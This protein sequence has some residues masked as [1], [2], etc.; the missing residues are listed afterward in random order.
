MQ[1]RADDLGSLFE[2]VHLG[3]HR[4]E[5]EAVGPVFRLPGAVAYAQLQ[6]TV[7]NVVDGYCCLRQQAR[8]P[9]AHAENQAA[10]PYVFRLRG[11]GSSIMETASKQGFRPSMTGVS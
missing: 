4:G 2:D 3:L 5:L 1:H 6:S 10:D 7:A 9:V 8:V 11:E